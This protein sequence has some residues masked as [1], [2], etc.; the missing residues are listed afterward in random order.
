M[1]YQGPE[2]LPKLALTLSLSEALRVVKIIKTES[3]T[4]VT[5]VWTEREAESY[6]F[7]GIEFQC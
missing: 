1:S 2:T 5:R 6:L 4:V 7:N 3:R